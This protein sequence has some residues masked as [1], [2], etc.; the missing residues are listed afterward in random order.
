MLFWTFPNFDPTF[1]NFKPVIFRD[2]WKALPVMLVVKSSL[3][4]V[5]S[6]RRESVVTSNILKYLVNSQFMH[7]IQ[8]SVNHQTSTPDLLICVTYN[9]NQPS[10]RDHETLSLSVSICDRDDQLLHRDWDLSLE[11]ETY[12]TKLSVPEY[13]FCFFSCKWKCLYA[14]FI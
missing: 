6:K 10:S 5:I 9:W 7:D 4:P 14:S 8:C 2:N 3:P 11:S 12:I 13:F 1:S